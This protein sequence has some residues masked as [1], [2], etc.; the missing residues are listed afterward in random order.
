MLGSF[1]RGTGPGSTS[2]YLSLPPKAKPVSL[3]RK[4]YPDA[5][6]QEENHLWLPYLAGRDPMSL[7]TD[8]LTAS[9]HPP[10]R[11]AELVA[12]FVRADGGDCLTWRQNVKEYADI[13]LHVC[14]PCVAGNVAEVRRCSTINCPFWPYPMGRNPHNTQRGV[15]P[16]KAA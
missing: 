12:A 11:T 5:G 7:P 6:M 3:R 1:W 8:L 13:R 10:R 9:G 16:F 15:N 14:L 2:G 4:S